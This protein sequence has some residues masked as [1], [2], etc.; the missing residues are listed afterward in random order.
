MSILSKIF[1][2]APT[3]DGVASEAPTPECA[4]GA[5]VPRWDSAEDM[6]KSDRIS[7]YLCEG[8]GVNLSPLEAA[9][10]HPQI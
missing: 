9:A 10:L 8:C 6:G 1:G 7:Y 4:H 5:L 2:G 3:R